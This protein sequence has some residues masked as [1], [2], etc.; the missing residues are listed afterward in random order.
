SGVRAHMDPATT[1]ATGYIA[2][3]LTELVES[4]VKRKV[5]ERWTRQR[6]IQFYRTFCSELL[7]GE[8]E[9]NSLHERLDELL[10]DD[11]KSEIVFE[12]YRSVCLSKSKRYGPRIIAI[13]V[14]GIVQDDG[15]ASPEDELILAAA[16]IL[17]DDELEQFRD[18]LLKVG[19]LQPPH[20]LLAE[21]QID[22]NFNS[23]TI[24]IT[25]SPLAHT[26]GVWAEK[27]K[28]LGLLTETMQERTFTYR[29]DSERHIDMD[30]SV[31]VISWN[32]I[33]EEPCRRLCELVSKVRETS[34]P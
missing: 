12:A 11:A 25:T 16:E 33:Y 2:D 9:G 5:I 14:A 19:H 24:E 10:E 18:E 28:S 34:A 8:L 30:G 32:L 23:S 6:A 21:R 13:V 1:A 20:E 27:L 26:H 17:S 22:S 29:E 3:K 4:L 7:N 15:I 31:R